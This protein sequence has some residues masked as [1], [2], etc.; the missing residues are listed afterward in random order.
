MSAVSCQLEGG[1][2]ENILTDG[3]HSQ[4]MICDLPPSINHHSGRLCCA[5]DNK[6]NI[7]KI[8]VIYQ[9]TIGGSCVAS[10]SSIVVDA[11]LLGD[12]ARLVVSHQK[13]NHTKSKTLH[14]AN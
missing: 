14:L 9:I 8:I 12:C 7:K 2:A 5:V 13:V 1:T 3:I 4:M 6:H 11:D 10:I